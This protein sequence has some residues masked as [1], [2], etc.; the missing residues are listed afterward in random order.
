MLRWLVLRLLAEGERHG[1]D[2]L[3]NLAE[4]GWGGGPGS[5]YPLLNLLE[6]EGLIAGRDEDGKRV[7]DLTDEGKELLH[8]RGPM[9]DEFERENQAEEQVNLVR[10]SA[11]KLMSAVMQARGA[12][13]ESRTKIAEVLDNARKE[14]YGILANE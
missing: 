14:V 9:F 13:S 5:V 3:K 4:R 8:E 7:Y 11:R 1:Y 12:S 10:D 2:I 6:E